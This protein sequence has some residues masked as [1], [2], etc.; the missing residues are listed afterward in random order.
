[1]GYFKQKRSRRREG[2]PKAALRLGRVQGAAEVR[3]TQPFEEWRFVRLSVPAWHWGTGEGQGIFRVAGVVRENMRLSEDQD[4]QL[5]STLRWFNKRLPC[6][7]IF[8]AKAIFWFKFSAAEC[9][10]RVSHLARHLRA[11]GVEVVV[12]ETNMP[13]RV[14]YEDDLQVAAVPPAQPEGLGP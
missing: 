7:R 2:V 6:P 8:D 14:I 12:T 3:V 4:R 5:A 9:R 13:G 10:R 11:L 1:M